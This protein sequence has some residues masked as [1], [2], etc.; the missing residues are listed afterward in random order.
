MKKNKEI[1]LFRS[2][3]YQR[4]TN[5]TVRRG[6]KW[7]GVVGEVKAESAFVEVEERKL[8]LRVFKTALYR[9]KDIPPRWLQ[10]EHDGSCHKYEGL[11][12]AMKDSYGE[13]FDEKE[14]VTVVF[15]ETIE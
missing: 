14:I 1:M 6:I 12:R 10:W 2:L 11:L 8:K 4:G 5:I 3:D 13:D 15:F 9:F 7:F